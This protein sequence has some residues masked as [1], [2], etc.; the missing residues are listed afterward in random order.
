MTWC[1][2]LIDGTVLGTQLTLRGALDLVHA[3]RQVDAR[4][5][6]VLRIDGRRA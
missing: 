1:L 2:T 6:F 5:R 3:E 4:A